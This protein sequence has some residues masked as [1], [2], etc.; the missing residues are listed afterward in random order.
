MGGNFTFYESLAPMTGVQKKKKRKT[1]KC[2]SFLNWSN[3]MRAEGYKVQTD[4]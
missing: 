1:K 3:I 2:L 4:D